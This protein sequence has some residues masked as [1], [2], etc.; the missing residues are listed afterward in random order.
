MA[1]PLK[2]RMK[3]DCS[4][5]KLTKQAA[6]IRLLVSLIGA[7]LLLAAGFVSLPDAAAQGPCGQSYTV[8]YGDTLNQ[9]AARC[10]TTVEALLRANPELDNPNLIY[11]GTC[12]EMP[13]E[14]RDDADRLYTVKPDDTLGQ[15]AAQFNTT[16]SALLRANPGIA[17]PDL[18][19]VGQRLTIREPPQPGQPAVTISPT[20]GP[21]GTTV[22][23]TARELPPTTSLQVG[24]GVINTEFGVVDRAATDEQ[25]RLQTPLTIP[26]FAEP[27]ETWVVVVRKVERGGLRASSNHFQVTAPQTGPVTTSAR[28]YLIALEDGGR[29]GPEIGCGDSLAPVEVTLE[30]GS[31]PVAAALARLLAIDSQ[32][33]GREPE[34]YN[35]LHRSSLQVEEVVLENGRAVIDL[36]GQLKLGGVCDNPRVRAQLEE[37]AR[38]F[39]AVE[40][41][42]IFINDRPLAEVLSQ[43]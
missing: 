2:I 31:N 18:I 5:L 13:A 40:Q 24:A 22:Q 6:T 26:D 3:R 42:E 37:T 16:V 38:Q 14:D 21:P 34:L 35:A 33:Y 4:P 32:R 36:A 11:V 17:D 39:P 29:L 10:E 19:T 41:V 43:K 12:L 25:G 20:R 15:L 27:G 30:A 9:I 23:V 28:I 8:V 1:A 7:V